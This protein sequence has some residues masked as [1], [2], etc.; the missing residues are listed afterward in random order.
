MRKTITLIVIISFL[1]GLIIGYLGNSI[2]KV[3]NAVAQPTYLANAENVYVDVA[4]S[5][6]E[7]SKYKYY[8]YSP[9]LLSGSTN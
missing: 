3:N 6:S 5:R 7:C 1:G 9:V 4:E 2:L 8:K